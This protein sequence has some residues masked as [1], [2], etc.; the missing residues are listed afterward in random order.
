MCVC[1]C[2][3][4]GTTISGRTRLMFG[5]NDGLSCTYIYI[6]IYVRTSGSITPAHNESHSRFPDRHNHI[7]IIA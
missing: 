4:G 1:V 3:G 7:W 6:Y 2:V 5:R